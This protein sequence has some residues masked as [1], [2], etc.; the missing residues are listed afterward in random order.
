MNEKLVQTGSFTRKGGRYS[1]DDRNHRRN[2][3]FKLH[4][5]MGY[6]ARRISELM[7]I[8]KKTINEDISYWYSQLTKDNPVNF[9][10]W[11]TKQMY[12][13]ESQRTR[14]VESLESQNNIQDKISVEKI[15]FEI[16][17][18][19]I[20]VTLKAATSIKKFVKTSCDFANAI[21]QNKNER[22]IPSLEYLD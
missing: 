17:T 12:R 19:M 18:E 9:E 22:K 7:K 14:L 11:F 20:S 3:V 5:E 6:P 2:E 16:D 13:L 21:L 8:N 4:F 15:I 1:T 10:T